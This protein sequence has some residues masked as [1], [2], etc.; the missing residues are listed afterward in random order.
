M[1]IGI[2]TYH[3]SHNYGALLQAI[4]LRLFLEE[5]GHDV[6]YVDYWPKYHKQMYQ[7]FD[8]YKFKHRRMGGKIGY[9]RTLITS[10]IPKVK[11]IEAFESFIKTFIVP[12]CKKYT[13]TAI[14]YDA[15]IYGSD[16]IWRKQERL[17]NAF[18]SMYFAQNELKANLHISYAASMGEI[19]VDEKD[20]EALKKM[21]KRFTSLGV[22]EESLKDLIKGLGFEKVE[23]NIDPT[24]LLNKDQW[25]KIISVKRLV[26]TKYAL[27]YDLHPKSFDRCN[28]NEYCINNSL[29]L[30][31]LEGNAKAS[32]GKTFSTGGPE[33]ML[34]LIA[35]ADTV[36]TSSYHGLVF[37][38][39]F[40]KNVYASFKTNSDRAKTLMNRVGI[41]R[42]LVNHDSDFSDTCPIDYSKVDRCISEMVKDSVYYIETALQV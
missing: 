19:C 31:Y 28:L 20:R 39:L 8:A 11:R 5:Q 32:D 12:Y 40:Q 2:L 21:F 18:N 35:F 41:E 9:I 23:L 30:I 13:D 29:D 27:V 17:N 37:S 4:A 24:L 36:F 38:L 42:R 10:F 33:V 7:L 6:Y 22:R 14:Q 25:T 26:A 15:I 34:S 3:R 1:K 16:Q